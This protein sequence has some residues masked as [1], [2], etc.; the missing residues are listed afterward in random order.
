MYETQ[1]GRFTF[2][3]AFR[4]V[5]GD[6]GL[7]IHV[8]GPTSDSQ[9]EEVLRFD[10][11]EKDPHYHL[12]WSYRNDPFIRIDAG[13]PFGWALSKLAGDIQT[14][15]QAASSL[16]MSEGEISDLESTLSSIERQGRVIASDAERRSG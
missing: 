6:R 7:A 11:F 4:H 1:N 8:F 3:V 13:D 15:L 2:R 10:C 12:A 5:E 9:E 14:L 16:P